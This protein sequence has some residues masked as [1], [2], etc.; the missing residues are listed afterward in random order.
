M[1]NPFV[2]DEVF[3]K[4]LKKTYETRTILNELKNRGPMDYYSTKSIVNFAISLREPN[5]VWLNIETGR[6]LKT[7]IDKGWIVS[8][9]KHKG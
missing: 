5:K 4:T 3:D 6:K 8:V 9:Y 1:V 2:I 7:W